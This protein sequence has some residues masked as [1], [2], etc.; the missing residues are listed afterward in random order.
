VKL[1]ADDALIAILIAAMDASGHVS[2]DE[3]ARAHNMIWSMR[4]FRNRSGEAVGRRIGRMR[5]LV[6]KHG[7]PPV[8]EAAAA[9]AIPARL[10]RAAFA[11]AADL[12]L[13][14]GRMDRLEARFLRVI[15]DDLGL[16][17]RTAKNILNVVRIKNSA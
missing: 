2:A 1:S 11:V 3:A 14:D 7:A 16:D 15:A 10:R 12:V 17:R 5:A 6:E 9:K 8:I 4:R 13:V